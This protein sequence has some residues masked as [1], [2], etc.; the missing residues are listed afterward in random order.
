MD[1]WPEIRVD[2]TSILFLFFCL[3]VFIQLWYVLLYPMRLAIYKKKETTS[4]MPPVS[5]IV[6]ARNEE[7]N[8]FKNLPSVLTQDYPKFEVIVVNDMSVD[9]SKHIIRAYQE[10]YPHL[11]I[12]ELEKNKH[13]KFG[14]KMPLTIGIKGA[15][16]EHLVMIDADCYPAGNQWLKTLVRNYTE[17]KEIII[18]VGPYET[19]KSFLNK[20][21]RF[22]TTI[23]AST[24]LSFTCAGKPYMA[25]GRNMSYTRKRFFEVDGFKS[26]YHIQSGD[27]DLFMR[28]A[29]TKK[30]VA[31]EISPDSFVFSHPKQTWAEWI[32]QKQRH[33]TTAP[34]YRL[35]NKLLLGIFP[36]SMIM[37]LLSSVILLF[38]FKWWWI[39]AG[40]L[41]IRYLVYWIVNRAVFRKLA[42]RDLVVWYPVLELIHLVVMP[43]IYYSTDRREPD[44]W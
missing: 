12:I 3:M 33:F 5:V 38:N 31:I 15:Q 18:G 13:R 2:F 22:D 28:D 30:N 26:H 23:I 19:E 11:R 25:V 39:I 29:A 44:K 10:K 4:A 43:F 36:A 41:F 35:I 34:R 17:G 21:I 7:D 27:D 32:K 24:Y 42:A 1:F 9:E 16:Y 6:C 14:K 40:L 37:M 8:L 20:L